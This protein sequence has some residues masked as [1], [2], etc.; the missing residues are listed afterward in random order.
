MPMRAQPGGGGE[1]STV[2][3]H[4]PRSIRGAC[5]RAGRVALRIRSAVTDRMV[6]C[7]MECVRCIVLLVIGCLP[8]MFA[9]SAGPQGAAAETPRTGMCGICV[10]FLRLRRPI[11]VPDPEV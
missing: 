5:A 10:P 3:L 2:S 1:L 11:V 4:G 8:G 6:T 9:I 7:A